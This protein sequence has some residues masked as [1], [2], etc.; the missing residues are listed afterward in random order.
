VDGFPFPFAAKRRRFE[1]AAH[2]YSAY[3]A[4]V[5]TGVL[6][7][8][9][10]AASSK[11]APLASAAFPV[12]VVRAQMNQ[13]AFFASLATEMLTMM[14]CADAATRAWGPAFDLVAVPA[15]QLHVLRNAAPDACGDAECSADAWTWRDAPRSS[16]AHGGVDGAYTAREEVLAA[17]VA[18]M[19]AR[20]AALPASSRSQHPLPDAWHALHVRVMSARSYDF[21]AVGEAFYDA[22]MRH[23]GGAEHALHALLARAG[24]RRT[25]FPTRNHG[26]MFFGLVPFIADQVAALSDELA[27]EQREGKGGA[28]GKRAEGAEAETHAAAE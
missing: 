21:G 13:R 11:L 28:T 24:S 3:A 1:L 8:F 19:L 4:I 12:D 10:R 7:P 27:A 25:V 14:D 2:V 26:A 15:S 9:L 17:V 22:Q 18:P 20:H 6:R 5:W 16:E 23:W